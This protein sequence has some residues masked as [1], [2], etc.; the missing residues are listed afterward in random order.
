[1]NPLILSTLTDNLTTRE[2]GLIFGLGGMI[3]AFVFG[4]LGMLLEHRKRAMWHATAR[5]ALEK[6]QPIPD[7]N[8]DNNPLHSNAGS[9]Q[10]G[11]ASTNRFRGLL[12]SGLVNIAVGAGLFI[13]MFNVAKQVAY[14]SAIPFFIGIALL[15]AAVVDRW[16]SP[17]SK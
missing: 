9:S 1:M 6:G 15:I 11:D 13:A 12:I 16:L 4:A 3:F 7:P 17:K 8:S 2:L 5:I 14:F 10:A